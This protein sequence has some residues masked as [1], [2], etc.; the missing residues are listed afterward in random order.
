MVVQTIEVQWYHTSFM[1]TVKYIVWTTV[2]AFCYMRHLSG[3]LLLSRRSYEI[4]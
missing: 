2:V 3:V 4:L 1:G